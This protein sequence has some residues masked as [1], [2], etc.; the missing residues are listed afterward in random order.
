MTDRKN[1]AV[2]GSILEWIEHGCG[3]LGERYRPIENQQGNVVAANEVVRAPCRDDLRN[4]DE[5]AVS[6]KLRRCRHL[7]PGPGHRI[8]KRGSRAV[9]EGRAHSLHTVAST[10]DEIRRDE[11]SRAHAEARV[12]ENADCKIVLGV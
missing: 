12:L 2:A 10:H 5:I 11:H 6:S 9:N 1:P 3:V 8:S 7:Q 4:S